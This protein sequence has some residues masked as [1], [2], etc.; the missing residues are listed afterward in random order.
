ML[1]C[2]LTKAILL[3]SFKRKNIKK[4]H[5]N[6]LADFWTRNIPENIGLGSVIYSPK[7]SKNNV[8]MAFAVVYEICCEKIQQSKFSLKPFDD[9]S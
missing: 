9:L 1:Q 4:F 7:E 6:I 5:Q 2:F 3:S 8:S